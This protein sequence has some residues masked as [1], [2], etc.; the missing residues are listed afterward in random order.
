M[1]F[2]DPRPALEAEYQRAAERLREET[3][4]PNNRGQRFDLA[5]SYGGAGYGFSV[6]ARVSISSP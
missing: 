4:E 5:W 6:W 2:V 3:G 1:R